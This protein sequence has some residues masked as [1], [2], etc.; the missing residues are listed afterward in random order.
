MLQQAKR[1]SEGKTPPPADFGTQREWR[2]A[3]LLLGPE[4][5]KFFQEMGKMAEQVS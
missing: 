4:Q 1:P 5:E 2:L 3:T